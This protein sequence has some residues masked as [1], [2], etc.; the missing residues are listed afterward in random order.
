VD[1]AGAVAALEAVVRPAAGNS[2]AARR[3]M[4]HLTTTHWTL[5]RCFPRSTLAAIDAACAASE[6][7]HRAEIRCAVET[8]LSLGHLWRGISSMERAVEVFSQLR[9]LDTAEN[10]GVL[11]YVL[12]AERRIEIVADRGFERYVMA[13]D[14]RSICREMEAAFASGSYEAGALATLDRITAIAREYFPVRGGDR[15]ELSNTTA[16]L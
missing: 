2:G 5:R 15:N 7:H 13:D 6:Q 8:V 4:Q 1:L 3:W 16:L 10:N 12:L 11:V 9:M 14:W